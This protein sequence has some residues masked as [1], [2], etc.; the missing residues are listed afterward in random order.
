MSASLT[1]G[2]CLCPSFVVS[3]TFRPD[4]ATDSRS[5]DEGGLRH[6]SAGQ[7]SKMQVGNDVEDDRQ[8]GDEGSTRTSFG[9]LNSSCAIPPA[10]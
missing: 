2:S 1:P 4:S 9:H 6:M 10:N 3:F 8:Q 5:R 7:E